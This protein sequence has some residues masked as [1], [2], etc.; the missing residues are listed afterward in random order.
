MNKRSEEIIK[1]FYKNVLNK[2]IKSTSKNV[3]ISEIIDIANK[4]SKNRDFQKLASKVA[5]QLSK[6]S[7][8]VDKDKWKK[9]FK[10]IKEKDKR[11]NKRAINHE[12]SKY[13]L[14]L[15]NKTVRK[16]FKMIKSIPKEIVKLYQ[17]KLIKTLVK[18]VAEGKISRG[19]FLKELKNHGIKNANVIARTETAKLQSYLD[20]TR[21]T[22]LG[23]VV[24]EW[25]SNNDIRTRQSHRDMNGVIVFWR[26]K[27]E[28]K[29]YLD[30]M[31]GNAGEFPNCRCTRLPIMFPDRLTKSTYKVYN[32][33]TKKVVEM[34]KN[35]L[36]EAIKKG[37]L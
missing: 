16:N 23:S 30:K 21:A 15:M 6:S 27:K 14:G 35:K 19:S 7:I 11:K 36:L 9:L 25:R 31:Y 34:N 28:E 26:D 18:E 20:E 22:D 29:P 5:V 10:E 12:Y 33:K 37:G 8:N 17:T 4:I 13:E 24:Y 3:T 32:Y 1:K 2:I